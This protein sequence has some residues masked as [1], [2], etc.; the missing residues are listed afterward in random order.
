MPASR[1]RAARALCVASLL[2][3]APAL[4]AQTVAVGYAPACA[5]ASCGIVRFG[6]TNTTA[7]LLS[8]ASLRLVAASNAFAFDATG[9][10]TFQALDSFGPLGGPVTVTGG[11]QLLA[12]FVNGAGFPFELAAG[13]TGFVDVE[14]AGTPAFATGAFTFTATRVGGGTVS[15]TVTATT[16]IPEPATVALTAAGLVAL[17]VSARRR[18]MR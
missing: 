6:V 5:S 3:A 13:A 4:R 9:T 2:L 1:F 16:V 11:T 12:D 8:L 15:G 7:S 17:A 18:R 10:P 14:L